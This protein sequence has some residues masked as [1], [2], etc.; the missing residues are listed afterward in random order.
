M[1]FRHHVLPNGLEI[2]AEVRPQ[3]YSCALAFFVRAGARDEAPEVSGVSHFLE[4][5]VFKGSHRRSA[6]QVNRE[7]DELSVGSNA[8]TS[9][10]QTVYFATTLPEDQRSLVELLADMLRPA[11]RPD[12]FETEKQV[13]LE[14][15][16]KYDDQPPYGAHEKCLA[17]FFGEHPL[18]QSILG[19]TA[20]IRAL[21][22]QQM[23]DYFEQR[24]SPGNIVLAAAGRVDFEGL[25]E[26]ATEYCG[27]W[28]GR[29]ALR[30]HP[31]VQPRTGFQVLHK[32]QAVQE[33]VVQ[34]A[35]GPSA[36][37]DDRYPARLLAAIVGDDVGSRMFWE[38]VDTGRAE[39]AT[40]GTQ[41]FEDA[42]AF[43]TWMA[44]LPELAADNLQR[45]R[46][47]V[48]QVQSEGV[49]EEELTR[50]KNKVCAHLVLHAERSANRLFAVGSSWL[51]RRDYRT[52]REAVQRYQ[53]VTLKDLQRVLTRFDLTQ[54]AT[55][56]VGPLETLAPPW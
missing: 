2:V 35:P 22:R 10:E 5:M 26:E 25:V 56:A 31:P 1:T 13:I 38:L 51:I 4:H 18:G 49:T 46:Q 30:H 45:I 20:S 11:L 50:A 43:C 14:E 3:A 55:V 19:T 28:T 7:L 34:L 6:E 47:I 29:A 41:E 44:C 12:D 52:V 24:Y 48:E 9:E 23:L 15:I 53:A 54:G 17:A 8:F 16:A 21:S 27:Q 33:Y 40:L 36:R 37:D 32:P 39:T 42:G